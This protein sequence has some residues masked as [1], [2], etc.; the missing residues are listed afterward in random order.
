MPLERLRAADGPVVLT[1]RVA[2]AV[3]EAGSEQTGAGVAAG[4]TAQ[5][6]L[7]V[8]VKPPVALMVRVDVVE[9]PAATDAEVGLAVRVKLPPPAAPTVSD[10]VVVCTVDPAVPVMV[11]VDVPAG[12]PAVV[13]MV[14]TEVTAAVVGVTDGGTNAQVAPV[15]RPAVQVKVTALVNPFEG[16]TLTVDVAVPA[17]A[18]E[19]GESAVAVTAKL[20]PPAAA[21]VSETVVISTTDPELPVM[22]TV[23]V[24]SG[25]PAVV[26]MVSTEV[27]A[28]VPGVTEGGTN[29][30]VAPAGRPVQASVTALVNPFDGVTLTVEVAEP[31]GATGEG[32]SGVAETV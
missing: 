5:A 3:A 26:V 27:T 17:G 31:P 9:A 6:R 24:A 12:V 13:V 32:A 22:V 16:A 19:A 11:T 14:S 30:Q 8:P 2:V 28:P 20:G 1:V 15:G 10:T 25:V 18:T 21:T 23:D 29:A 7:T 4:V